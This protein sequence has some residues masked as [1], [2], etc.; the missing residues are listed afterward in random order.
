MQFLKE[1]NQGH[2][3]SDG[4]IGIIAVE[5]LSI[6]SRFT[7]TAPRKD[8]MCD[9][10]RAILDHHNFDRFVLVSHSYGSVITTHLL[11]TPNLAS[12]VSS[13]VLIDP[14]SILLHQ[15]DVAYNFTVRK[16]KLAS[17]WLLW[18]FGSKDIGVAHTL[19]RTFFWSENILWK[20]DLR[21][22]KAT[23]YLGGRDAIINAAQIRDY[24]LKGTNGT[25]KVKGEGDGKLSVVWCE[26]LNHGE[27]FD[28]GDWR[29]GLR[30]RVVGDA[31]GG[32]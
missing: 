6:S 9:Q 1:L 24:L 27:V 11:R 22:Y 13:V 17:E 10:I 28:R 21:G 15:P 25:E 2:S 23:V 18:Y 20:E 12:R 31:R 14:I 5:I 26:G 19:A 3:P 7:V 32:I 29:R 8:N 16:P 4:D 30:E